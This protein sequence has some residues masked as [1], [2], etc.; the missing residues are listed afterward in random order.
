MAEHRKEV[1]DFQDG[2]RYLELDLFSRLTTGE[3][4]EI[5]REA[6]LVVKELILEV[7]DQ[8]LAYKKQFPHEF[9]EIL[10]K[11]AGQ[12]TRDDCLIKAHL[13]ILQKPEGPRACSD[14]S[15][16]SARRAM[17]RSR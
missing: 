13:L 12:I 11:Y 15:Y 6:G 7:S 1:E 10:G 5:Y 2:V 17:T 8:A 4:L 3:Y 14:T 9:Q 16:T